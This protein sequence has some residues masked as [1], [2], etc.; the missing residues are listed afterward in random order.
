MMMMSTMLKGVTLD[1]RQ[2]SEVGIVTSLVH[3]ARLTSLLRTEVS[4]GGVM[5]RPHTRLLVA[6][7]ETPLEYVHRV[8]IL[9]IGCC[10]HVTS[11]FLL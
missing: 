1:T 7:V 11:C 4:M 5:L 10:F 9:L 8:R 6:R 3:M 2:T